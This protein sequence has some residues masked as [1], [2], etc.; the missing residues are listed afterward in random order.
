VETELAPDLWQVH[1]DPGQ[2]ELAVLNLAVNAR[3]AMPKGGRLLLRTRNTTLPAT[4]GRQAG[5]YV[6]LDVVDAGIGMPPA[7][8]SRA[9][10]PF[11]TTK[12]A[13]RGTGL[14][15]P[16][17]FGFT[18]QSGGDLRLESTPGQGTTVTIKL[19]RAAE[20]HGTGDATAIGSL[21]T[22]KGKSV[23]VV[24]DNEAATTAV[25]ALEMLREGTTVD[26]VFSDVVLP[27]GMSGNELAQAL[28]ARFPQVA[29]VL[30]TGYGGQAA[31]V[32]PPPTVETLGKPYQLVELA[33]ALERALA[34]VEPEQLV[35]A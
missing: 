9:L 34:R 1:A 32:A 5:D 15:L 27:G 25:Q 28:R 23:L 8:L 20:D 30:A 6:C 24:E 10:E 13:G 22:P 18:R 11:F 21:R 17:V 26:A 2:M 19:P 16:Q 7:V 31:A 29:V 3:D 12:E 4:E 35:K 14:G 33:A